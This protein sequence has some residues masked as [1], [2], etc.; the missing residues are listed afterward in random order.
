MPAGA[1]NSLPDGFVV[2]F[3]GIDGCGKTT[4]AAILHD[5]IAAVR[6]ALLTRQ[7]G[8]CPEL[9]LR[10]MLL[11]S[12]GLD[13]RARLLL[14]AADNAHHVAE[15]VLPAVAEGR[16]VVQ[17]RSFG[18]AVAYQA[19][20]EGHDLD[21][22]RTI[23]AWAMRGHE[24]DLTVFLD[25]NPDEARARW[26]GGRDAIESMPEDFH[27]RVYDGYLALA[28][29]P[30][31]ATVRCEP[32]ASADDIAGRVEGAVRARMQESAA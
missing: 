9:N 24:P 30:S 23:Y 18:S 15:V 1:L 22:V 29:A 10:P 17:D 16:V 32:E 6:P 28:R 26:T 11:G 12:G 25:M 7:P 2:A 8:G 27:R 13:P 31:W 14:F 5:R 4:Q 20:G 21:L 19:Y 3:E